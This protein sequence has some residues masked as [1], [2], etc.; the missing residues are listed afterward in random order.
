MVGFCF[1]GNVTWRVALEMPE[2]L[3]AVPFYGPVP[4]LD[5]VSNMNAAVLGIYGEQD[6]RVNRGIPDAESKMQAAGKVY[7]KI[8]YPGANHAFHNDTSSRY[9]Q[10]AATDAWAWTIGWFDKYLRS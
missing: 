4:T 6:R 2:V 7:E 8:I 3:A 1:G 5:N 10:E 9:N